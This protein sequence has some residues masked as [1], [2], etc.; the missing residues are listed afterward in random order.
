MGWGTKSRRRQRVLAARRPL[1]TIHSL[2]LSSQSFN[3]PI[4]AVA[5]AVVVVVDV[6]ASVDTAFA[7]AVAVARCKSPGYTHI[8]AHS[9]PTAPKNDSEWD[10]ELFRCVSQLKVSELRD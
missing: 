8:R 2:K 4:F 9:K 6:D 1:D 10:L 3:R 5:V 7:F